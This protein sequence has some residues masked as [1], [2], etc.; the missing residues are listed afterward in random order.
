MRGG[1]S[2]SG[3]P[4]QLLALGG[5]NNA[6]SGVK[7]SEK[8]SIGR[9]RW[10]DIP[11]LNIARIQPGSTLL[12]CE[13]AFCFCGLLGHAGRPNSIES[14]QLNSEAEWSILLLNK[15]GRRL[16]NL[17][18]VSFHNSILVFGGG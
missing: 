13:Q 14:M 17:A 8:Y 11:P 3:T 2:L 7:T 18:C 12:E 1:L 4:S 5:S 10:T 15:K 6:L 9:N 16:S